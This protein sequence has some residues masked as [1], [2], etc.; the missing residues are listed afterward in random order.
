MSR[1]IKR[2]MEKQRRRQEQAAGE[3]QQDALGAAGKQRTPPRQFMREVRGEL[4]R[5]AWPSR[6]EVTSYSIVV[7]I[8]VSLVMLYVFA[9]DQAFGQLVF[10]IFQ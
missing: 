7:L 8:A 10:W 2:D 4:K 6:R 1:E 3:L 9:L 5:V